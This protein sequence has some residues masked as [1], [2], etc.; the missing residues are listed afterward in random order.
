MK[1][2]FKYS[3]IVVSAFFLFSCEKETEDISR[4]TEYASFEMQGDNFMF[5]LSNSTFTDPGVTAHEGESD[6]PVEI[7]GTVNASIP[8]VYTIQ[9]LAKNSD[10]FSASVERTVVVVPS[11]P[12]N[13]L[14]GEYQIVHATR[15]NKI[16]IT[17]NNGIVGYYHATDSWWQSSPIPLDFVDMGDGTIK[18]LSGSSPYGAHYG[19][20]K[21]LLNGQIQF[22]VTLVNQG[23]LNYT[24]TYQIQ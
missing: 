21:I 13:D 16:K 12:T 20:G 11:M 17:K 7:K 15:K 14:S 5:V 19:T 2:L 4:V 10:G 18:I 8:D 24:T 1:I 9:Y 6:L 3:L 22:T 23:P